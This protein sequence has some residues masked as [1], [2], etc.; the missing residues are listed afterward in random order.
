MGNTKMANKISKNMQDSRRKKSSKTLNK[1]IGSLLLPTETPLP[2]QYIPP[3]L[4]T[5]ITN[6]VMSEKIN[7]STIKANQEGKSAVFVS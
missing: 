4:V 2:H 1:P 7:R 3:F 6:W 5:K